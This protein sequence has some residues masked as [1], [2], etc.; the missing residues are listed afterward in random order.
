MVKQVKDLAVEKVRNIVEE[1]DLKLRNR[2]KRFFLL[3]RQEELVNR[4]IQESFLQP[5]FLKRV[6]CVGYLS[7][8]GTLNRKNLVFFD[9]YHH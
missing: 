4:G 2:F 8:F 5:L 3:R 9:I 7:V 1:I 6:K